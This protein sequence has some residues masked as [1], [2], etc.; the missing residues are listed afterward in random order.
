MD[1]DIAQT[2]RAAALEIAHEGHNGWGNVC[3]Y[4]ADE[5][6]R[7]RAELA[8]V[9]AERDDY[10]LLYREAT[11]RETSRILEISS[12]RVELAELAE[13]R[14]ERDEWK[15]AANRYDKNTFLRWYLTPEFARDGERRARAAEDL[16][17]AAEMFMEIAGTDDTD[18]ASDAWRALR[19]AIHYVRKYAARR[20]EG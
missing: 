11:E 15:R 2:L 6:E 10:L 7:L 18:T 20:G 13:A 4:A 17:R 8:S 12:L 3:T 1:D 9:K 5:I 16:C 19:R 14:R